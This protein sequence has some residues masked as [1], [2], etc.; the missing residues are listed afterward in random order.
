MTGR[1]GR[2]FAAGLRVL[3]P[4]A[5]LA[6]GAVAVLATAEFAATGWP[7]PTGLDT[8]AVT[9]VLA[10]AV[11]GVAGSAEVAVRATAASRALRALIRSAHQP[12]PPVV[13]DAAAALGCAARLDVVAGEDAFAVTYAL[14]RP[15]I[16]VSA[17]L[18][19]ALTAGEISAVLAHEREHPRR[20]DP[21]CAAS[22]L[23]TVPPPGARDAASWPARCSSWPACPPAR[24]SRRP[25]LPGTGRGRWKPG[26]PS[27]RQ[28][29][30]RGS[31]SP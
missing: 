26:W 7:L 13:R 21:P 12:V 5:V 28:A 22:W 3:L 27:W 19:G 23:L 8:G 9:L 18:A 11:A 16:L 31:S 25:A 30:R 15:R 1:P 17:G 29:V 6:H 10:S 4:L 2:A 20:R 24:R 14:I